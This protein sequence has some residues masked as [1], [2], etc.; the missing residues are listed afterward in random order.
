MTNPTS[1][2][3]FA[4]FGLLLFLMYVGIRRR[5]LSQ[6]LIAAIGITG[7]IALVTLTGLAQNNT[8]YQALF[9][10][11]LVGGLFSGG[12]LAIAS[13]FQ[14]AEDRHRAESAPLNRYQPPDA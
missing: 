3:F 2:L 14:N 11:I 4:L 1:W 7:S 5:W 13:Y 6:L 10:G 12:T 9:A 8:I